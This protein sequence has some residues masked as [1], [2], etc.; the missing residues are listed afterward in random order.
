MGAN[1]VE[2]TQGFKGFVPLG[3]PDGADLCHGKREGLG[4]NTGVAIILG[5]SLETPRY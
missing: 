4:K 2:L 5:L 1:P 3:R